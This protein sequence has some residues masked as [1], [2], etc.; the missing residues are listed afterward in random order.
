MASDLPER[1]LAGPTRKASTSTAALST[2]CSTLASSRSPRCITGTCRRRCRTSTA[3]GSRGETV[4]AFAEYA[5]YVAEQLSDLVR[6]FFTINEFRNMV[7]T[8]HRGLDLQVGGGKTVHLV[9]AP[10]L[11]LGPAELNQVRHRSQSPS[12]QPAPG[13]PGC[14]F[15]ACPTYGQPSRRTIPSQVSTITGQPHRR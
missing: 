12:G 5:G 10:G 8:G 15:D 13:T 1:A 6:H 11:Q 14:T 2:N 3:D 9:N 4:H 7:D